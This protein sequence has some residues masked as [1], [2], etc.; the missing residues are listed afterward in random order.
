MKTQ[1][2]EL[3]VELVVELQ[4]VIWIV[5]NR[6]ETTLFCST[7][8]KNV[9]SKV[10]TKSKHSGY[11]EG[12]FIKT[13][14]RIKDSTV[15]ANLQHK[16]E[17]KYPVWLLKIAYIDSIK[18]ATKKDNKKNNTKRKFQNVHVR[19]DRWHANKIIV[20]KLQQLSVESF[21]WHMWTK[22]MLFVFFPKCC[23]IVLF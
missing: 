2:C 17:K 10:T 13:K 20:A 16:K 15:R 14:T 21:N 7:E 19:A 8:V 4:Q 23:N 12:K 18:Y 6:T 5:A 22:K 11:L 9:G 1:Q 3:W